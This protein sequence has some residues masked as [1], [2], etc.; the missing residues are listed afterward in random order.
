M[1]GAARFPFV[2]ANPAH[3]GTSFLPLLPLRL[4]RGE[5]QIEATAL[6]D[7]GA[8]VNVLPFSIGEQLGFVWTEEKTPLALTGNLARLPARGVL[9]SATV[10]QFTPARLVFAWTQADDIRII[11]GQTNFFV[12]FDAC[13]FRARLRFEVKPRSK[14]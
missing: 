4:S 6:L 13:F 14:P 5:Q 10:A 2:D 3:P 8:T 7:T 12:E 1:K 11:L 9:V